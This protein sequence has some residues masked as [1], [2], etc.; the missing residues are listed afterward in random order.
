ML[1]VKKSKYSGE[2]FVEFVRK[3]AKY[4]QVHERGWSHQRFVFT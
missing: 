4:V 3:V 1:T 2:T